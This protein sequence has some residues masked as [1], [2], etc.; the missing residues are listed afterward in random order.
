MPRG[1]SD[2]VEPIRSDFAHEPEMAELI[3]LFVSELGDRSDSI[4]NALASGEV[5]LL[6]TE[7]HRLKGAAPGYGFTPI[8][9]AAGRLEHLLRSETNA[10]ERHADEIQRG[11]DELIALC[12]RAII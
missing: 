3:E 6:V 9:E 1:P 5:E 4:R 12:R 7:A 2:D 10:F 8:G 11:V